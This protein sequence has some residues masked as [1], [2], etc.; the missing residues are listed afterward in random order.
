LDDLD[1]SAS[2]SGS[3][4]PRRSTSSL[5]EVLVMVQI[6]AKT[7]IIL[8]RC[9]AIAAVASFTCFWVLYIYMNSTRP[10]MVDIA[11]GRI[12]ALNNH[13]SIAYLTRDEHT[14]LYSFEYL[15]IGLFVVAWVFQY[16]IRRA[17]WTADPR[18]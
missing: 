12:Y 2:F 14:F 11:A 16:K 4:A 6:S 1:K 7:T 15:A 9:V 5:D 18:S 8:G 3:E 17:N 10:H 13:G